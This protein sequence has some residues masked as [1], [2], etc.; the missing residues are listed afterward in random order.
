MTASST[1]SFSTP[2]AISLDTDR[3][4][5]PPG[6]VARP[7]DGLTVLLHSATGRYFSLDPVGARAWCLM[8][9]LSALNAVHAALLSEF[10][11]SSETLRY[12]L[13]VLV[14]SLEARG[15]LKVR[16]G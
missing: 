3:V 7:V 1:A 16:R 4:E 11:V 5:V 14:A 8:T 13:E 10:D 6:V 9:S 12:D 15:L 2:K